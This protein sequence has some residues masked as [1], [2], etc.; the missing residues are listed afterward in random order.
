MVKVLLLHQ[1]FNT[2]QKGGPLR[3]YFIARALAGKGMIPV[4]ITSHNEKRYRM[5]KLEEI[6]VHYLP[7]HYENSFGFYRRIISFLK[8]SFQAVSLARSFKDIIICY[9]ISVPLTVGLAA[10]MIKT[11]Y[12]VPFI[13][14]VGD[15]WPDVPVKMG[16]IKN[17]FLKKVLYRLEKNIYSRAEAIVAL[18][19]PIKE[20]ILE[21]V[22]D[23]RVL[24]IEN[25]AD[26]GFFYPHNK[27]A[28]TI[29]RFGTPNRFVVSYLG[30]V[31]F[32]NGLEYFL[33][34]ADESRKAGLEVR[35]I[36]CGEGAK[37]KELKVKA[38]NL[39]LENLSF[40]PFQNRAGVKEIMDISDACFICYRAEKILE[41]G[42]PNKYFDGLAAGKLIIINFGGWIRQEIEDEQCGLFMDP[43]HA[44][45]FPE[46]ILPF[47]QDNALLKKFQQRARSLAERKY[48]RIQ[49]AEKISHLIISEGK[50]K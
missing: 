30:A 40:M 14:E 43:S 44:D 19:I 7:V 49:L 41:T 6:E 2:P 42:S 34:C 17:K 37:W 48:S 29:S 23:K 38:E 16:I 32:A 3:S 5:E 27:N 20:L 36:L 22:P 39:G 46:K 25:M 21:K 35:F 24:V 9:A 28:D 50:N 33:A 12:K 15:L 11:L 8:F 47:V 13:F 4:V 26:T 1:H 18:S 31:G 10:I 45:M